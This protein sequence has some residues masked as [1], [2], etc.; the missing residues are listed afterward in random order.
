MGKDGLLLDAD[1]PQAI[2]ANKGLGGDDK[3]EKAQQYEDTSMDTGSDA[4][5]GDEIDSRMDVDIDGETGEVDNDSN[6]LAPET[7]E[8]QSKRHL[9]ARW[10]V[11]KDLRK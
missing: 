9:K 3:N 10:A 8:K 2:D 4:G 11:R 6:K 7:F 5:P 1:Q